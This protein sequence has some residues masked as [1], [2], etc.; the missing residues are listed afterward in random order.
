MLQIRGITIRRYSK[1]AIKKNREKG[2]ELREA[3]KKPKSR[4]NSTLQSINHS[5]WK[6]SVQLAAYIFQLANILFLWSLVLHQC[7]ALPSPPECEGGRNYTGNV[8]RCDYYCCK[9]EMFSHHKSQLKRNSW[10]VLRMK[11]ELLLVCIR[12]IF[13]SRLF[14]FIILSSRGEHQGD[15]MGLFVLCKQGWGGQEFWV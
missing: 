6:Y 15:M 13:F 7:N 9:C 8:R 5:S 14:Y 3:K 12:V 11:T 1:K 4:I 2:V 10:F